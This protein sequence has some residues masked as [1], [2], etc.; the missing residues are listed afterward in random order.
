MGLISPTSCWSLVFASDTNAGQSVRKDPFS[1]KVVVLLVD[2][3][4]FILV[5]PIE[6]TANVVTKNVTVL[7]SLVLYTYRE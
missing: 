6:R 1:M 7:L 5:T 2:A 4:M 3:N